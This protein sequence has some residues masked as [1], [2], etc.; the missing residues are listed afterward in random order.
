RYEI[1]TAHGKPFE[2]VEMEFASRDDA[3]VWIINNQ[4]SRRNL[5]PFIRGELALKRK[6]IIAAKAKENQ[7]RKPK[8]VPQNSVEQKIDTQKELAKIAGVARRGW[9]GRGGSLWLGR[10][11]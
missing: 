10:C 2:T 8:S 5:T 11:R 7:I 4:F 1:C 6:H 9:A 3:M